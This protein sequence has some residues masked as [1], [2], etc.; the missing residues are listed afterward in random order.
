[1][2]IVAVLATEACR[3]ILSFVTKERR[4]YMKV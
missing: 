2:T 1:V 4:I 3:K